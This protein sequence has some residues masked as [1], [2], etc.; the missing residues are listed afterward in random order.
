MALWTRFTTILRAEGNPNSQHPWS[1]TTL[2]RTSKSCYDFNTNKLF[3]FLHLKSQGVSNMD[4]KSKDSGL[5]L[6]AVGCLGHKIMKA[7]VSLLV[8][9][10]QRDSVNLYGEQLV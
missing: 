4:C 8:T 1:L 9:L 7:L 10:H 5:C 3:A 2:P 6:S